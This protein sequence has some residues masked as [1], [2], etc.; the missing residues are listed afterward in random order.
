MRIPNKF[1]FM[2]GWDPYEDIIEYRCPDGNTISIRKELILPV[3]DDALFD[4]DEDDGYLSTMMGIYMPSTMFV[5]KNP[6]GYIMYKGLYVYNELYIEEYSRLWNVVCIDD[7]ATD[8]ERVW[9][10][11]VCIVD[12]DDEDWQT[13]PICHKQDCHCYNDT[14]P[15]ISCAPTI[16]F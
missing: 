10:G 4:D 14:K 15:L 9:F 11:L 7:D 3:F 16:R 5:P 1:D 6:Q 12:D 8:D 13:C 2:N